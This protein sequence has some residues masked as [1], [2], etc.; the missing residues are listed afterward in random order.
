[1]GQIG[2]DTFVCVDCETTGLDVDADAIIEVAVVKFTFDG[3]VDKYETLIDPQRPI[4]ASSTEIHH[5]TDDMVK[6]KPKIKEVIEGLL[7]FIGS[8]PIMGHGVKFDIDLLRRAAERSEIPCYIGKNTVIDTLRLGRLYGES[9][10]NSLEKLREHFNIAAEG[11]HRAMSDVVVNV[12]V[13]KRL[14]RQFDTTEKMLKRLEKPIQLRAMPLGKHKGRP[15][16]EIPIQ[17]L[18]WAAN[19]DFD[20]DLLFSIR[21]EIKRRKKGNSFSQAGNPFM[22]L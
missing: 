9:P 4:P 12:E 10:V 21:S 1:M 2:K 16:Q 13:F 6:G 14:V 17:Y 18:Q 3:I 19:K 11:A 8:F 7:D 15:F 20:M 22:G 5:I